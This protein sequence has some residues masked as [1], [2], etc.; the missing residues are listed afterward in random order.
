MANTKYS[1]S[2]LVGN[3]NRELMPQQFVEE[4]EKD[5]RWSRMTLSKDDYDDLCS[6]Y[7]KSHIDAME[8]TPPDSGKPEFLANIRHYQ[9]TIPENKRNI[10]IVIVNEKE[11]AISIIPLIGYKLKLCSLHLYL[12]PFNTIL[13]AFEL[14]ESGSDL[15]DLTLAHTFLM[16]WHWTGNNR[17]SDSTKYALTDLTKPLTDYLKGRDL[18]ALVT[19]GNKMKL[20]Q[21]HQFEL[22]PFMHPDSILYEIASSSPIGAVGSDNNMAPS[23]DY[24]NSIMHDNTVSVFANWKG[25]SL[26]D[27]FTVITTCNNFNSWPFINLYFPYIYLR[28][29]FEKSFCFSRNNDYRLDKASKDLLTEISEMEKYYFYDNISFNFL[30]NLLYHSMA[31]G[32]NISNEREGISKQI[33]ERVKEQKNVNDRLQKELQEEQ[34]EKEDERFNKILAYVTIF[35]VFSVVWDICSIVMKAVPPIDSPW[36]ALFFIAL[37]VIVAASFVSQIK[38]KK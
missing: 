5:N 8:D 10:N 2:F 35:A 21:V 25:L 23:L 15:N 4:I 31:K 37:G 30:P 33:K 6:I 34:K 17:F 36:T 29:F 24:F 3:F 1:H 18:A 14:D 16:P 20:F 19:Q 11:Y 27:S 32:M 12:F 9:C 28:C 22:E 38:K 13:F 26:V 7:Y